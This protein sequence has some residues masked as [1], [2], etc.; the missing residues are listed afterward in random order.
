MTKLVI[1]ESPAKAR[2]IEA[3]LGSDFVVEASVGHIRDLAEP[4]QLPADMKKGPY[5]KFA[6]NTEDGFDPY[7]IVDANKKKTVTEL[8]RLL[9][10][11][12]ELYLATDE[13][14][15]GEAIAWHLLQ[16]L[17]PKV[18]VK[19]MVFHEI[20]K[21]AI[22]R[23]L[24]NT[25]EIDVQL[26]DAQESRR[27]LDRLYGYE[28][29]PVLWRKV[30]GGLS[31]G[32]VQSVATRLVVER[33]RE[34]MAFVESHY[35]SVQV[36]VRGGDEGKEETFKARLTAVDDHPVAQGRDF[37]DDG[38]LTAS[39]IRKDVAVLD[40]ESAKAIAKALH[41]AHIG[42]EKVESKPSKR[43]PAPPFTTS[44]LQQEASRKLGL[45]SR[46]TMS[47][48]QQLYENGFI[49]YMRTDSVDLSKEAISAARSQVKERYGATYVPD[50]PRYY[51]KKAKGAQE[52]HEAIRP[53]GDTFRTPDQVKNAL[54]GMQYKLYELI[55]KRTLASQM[56]DAQL[57]TVS[58][59][60]S[61][62]VDAA[63]YSKARLSASGTVV[64][65][66][67]F[68][69]VYEEGRDT[70]RYEEKE[71]ESRLPELAEGDIVDVVDPGAV[72]DGH[73]TT[74]PPRFTDA[75]L[76]SKLE[77][78]GIGRPSTYAS[79]ISVITD[80]GYV[81]RR[82]Q[83]LVPTWVAF[84][85]VRLLEENL[86]GYVDYDFTAQMETSLDS[87]AAGKINRV[88]YLESF[89]HGDDDHKGLQHEVENLG[90]IDAR[91][92]NT[93]AIGEGID[94]RVGKFGPY[95]E[96]QVKDGDPVRASVPAELTP[97]ELT[98]EKA[99]QLI[100]Q[101]KDDGKVLGQHPETG[102][103]IVAKNGRFGPY[104]TEVLA[105]DAPKTAKPKT[106]SL[107]KNMSLSTIT[108]DEAMQLLSLPREVGKDAEGIAITA[109]NGKFGPYLK[110]GSDS[111]SLETEEQ[112]LTITV[113]EAEA[114]F[115]QP[116]RRG[117]AAAAAPLKELGEDPVSKKPVVLKNGRFGH[118]VTDGEINASLRVA[119]SVETITPERAYELLELRREKLKNDP[120]KKKPAARKTAARK[121]TTTKTAVK[122]TT[123]KSSTAKTAS[124]ST[125]SA[126]S[127]STTGTTAAKR[128]TTRKPTKAAAGEENKS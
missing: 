112:L 71:A 57:L 26:V 127:K 46:Q 20:T 41:D 52:A 17:K 45:N 67:G 56:S 120:P 3:Y 86:P 104:V 25:R 70:S 76:V 60:M 83:S 63:G 99:K 18:P 8:K 65:F 35:W 51:S 66:P 123:A 23:A 80:R 42:V 111:R 87:I 36:K 54:S 5:G 6:V 102:L 55:W 94:L 128:T 78:L 2:T 29:S 31:A 50:S 121:T 64:T 32:R 73:V 53:A 58:V 109:Q 90:E 16:V 82:G 96:K 43:R 61:T 97:D 103:D 74:P 101:G 91:A 37:S 98:V 85:V 126:T 122:S 1:V 107:F 38:K 93:M 9:K 116:K 39:A 100:E 89:Y 14:R 28:V 117:R 30:G 48:A 12:D 24:E 113:E 40:E 105:E 92:L 33:E 125:K 59:Q 95:I 124:R 88:S 110:K 79:T 108:F 4:K 44:T 84:S 27:I 47:Q 118:Y 13:D 22:S 34:R 72:A 21:E 114:I 119:D 69:A 62:G 19:R 75:S 81:E 115:A 7:Y 11:A 15:E 49:T 77:E 10:D 68:L 106:A